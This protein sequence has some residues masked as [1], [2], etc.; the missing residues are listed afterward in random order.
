MIKGVGK[1]IILLNNTDSD[2]FEQAIFI[3]R[4]GNTSDHKDVVK[5]CEK[6]MSYHVREKCGRHTYNWWKT[7]FFLL[8]TLVIV[9]IIYCFAK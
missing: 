9:L 6:M 4:S 3:L 2:I 1:R 7:G 8:L 5:E